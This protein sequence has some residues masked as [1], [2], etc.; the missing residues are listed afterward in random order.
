MF[1]VDKLNFGKLKNVLR[2]II[3]KN[4]FGQE[5]NLHHVFAVLQFYLAVHLSLL[6]LPMI[7]FFCL[8]QIFL[9]AK[10]IQR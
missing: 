4:A 7:Q 3:H 5:N 6:L 9:R 1:F 8:N 10:K 2:T